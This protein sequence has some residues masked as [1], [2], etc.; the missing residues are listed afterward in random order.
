MKNPTTANKPAA[1]EIE[2]LTDVISDALT[3][4]MVE[5]AA[6]TFGNVAEVADHISEPDTLAAI[7]T[8]LD[9]VTTLHRTGGLVSLFELI[10]YFNAMRNAT[11]DS[12]VERGAVFIEHMI[13]N[14]ATE[15]IA[16]LA[17]NATEAMQEA[18][19][20]TAD[21]RHSGGLFSTLGMLSKPE[22]QASL[23]FLLTFA[24]KLQAK[25]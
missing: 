9:E 3:D 1:P 21:T 20:E 22:T 23:H 15:E 2:R 7:H 13:N 17:S 24:K 6:S 18:A 11:T 10:H 16:S 12:I 4:S 5:R 19:K 14:L 8:I 25:S